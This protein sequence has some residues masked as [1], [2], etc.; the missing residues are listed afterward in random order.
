MSR[1]A[2]LVGPQTP[3]GDFA[4]ATDGWTPEDARRPLPPYGESAARLLLYG[5]PARDRNVVVLAAKDA[6]PPLP[7]IA[8]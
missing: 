4:G 1:L 3:S 7:D 2:H 6:P 8:A 5:R